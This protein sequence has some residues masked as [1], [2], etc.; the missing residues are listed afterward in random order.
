[1]TGGDALRIGILHFTAPP[2]VG[3]VA[4]VSGLVLLAVASRNSG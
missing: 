3:G 4:L 2:I 1:M